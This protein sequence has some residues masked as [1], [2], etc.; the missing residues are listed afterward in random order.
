MFSTPS[1]V[2]FDST[3]ER[4]RSDSAMNLAPLAWPADSASHLYQRAIQWR[5]DFKRC[6]A[7]TWTS[8][9]HR[10]WTRY[11]S[12]DGYENCCRYTTSD[13]GFSPSTY[14]VS[15]KAPSA[16]FLANLNHGTNLRRRDAIA[17]GRCTDGLAT[18]TLL[19]Y[20][21]LSY[22]RKVSQTV[23]RKKNLLARTKYAPFC[24]LAPVG[25]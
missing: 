4:I 24:S 1:R 16:N 5:R 17:T 10:I 15:A 13:K 23:I 21:S 6:S 25:C 7:T 22:R 12:R 2:H 19:C 18:K 14:L 8:T 20:S 3:I 11:T 9:R